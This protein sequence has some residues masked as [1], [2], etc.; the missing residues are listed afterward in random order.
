M[1][2]I[3]QLAAGYSAAFQ[4]PLI[5]FV[6]TSLIIEMTPGP[7]MAYLAVLGASRGRLAGFSAVLGVALG[8]ALLGVAVGLGA[9]SLIL[10]NPVAYETLRWAGAIYL[11]WLAYDSW[12]DAHQ[13]VETASISQS[14]LVQFR[15][16]F[17]TNLLNPKAALFFIA[18]IPEFISSPAPSIRELAALVSIYVAVATLVHSLIVLLAG[19]LQAF[20]AAPQR[21]ETA[22]NVFAVVLFLV[23]IW[24]FVRGY[25]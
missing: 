21:R 11:C 18:V 15:R 14:L 2:R 24:L 1:D 23:A 19:T 3:L 12:K 6:L 22:G 16:G 5:A 20:L 7:N 8:L 13:P 10:N 25:R 17:I 4:S 9:G